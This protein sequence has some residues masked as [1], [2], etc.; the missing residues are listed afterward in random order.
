MKITT[1]LTITIVAICAY[2]AYAQYESSLK[3]RVEAYNQVTGLKTTDNPVVFNAKLEK[4]M[5]S[6]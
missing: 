1:I 6:K 5:N 2:S 3:E 4:I